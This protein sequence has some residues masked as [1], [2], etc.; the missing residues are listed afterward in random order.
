MIGKPIPKV[1]I[2]AKINGSAKFGVDVR[3]PGMLFAAVSQS[4]V[5]GGQLKSYDEVAAK[6]IRG[7]EYVV[8]IPN[9]VAVVAD[10]NWHANE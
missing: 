8:P 5:F 2:P 10:T 4:P 7:V 3:L 6:G 1:H 9:G